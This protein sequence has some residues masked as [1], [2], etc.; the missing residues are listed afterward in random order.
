MKVCVL[1]LGIIGSAWAG[2]LIEDGH[3]VRVWNRTP[4]D[5]PGFC[6]IEEAVENAEAIF[7]V[8]ADPAAVESVLDSITPRLKAGQTVIQAST[9]S[10]DWS[11]KFASQVE[12][13]G[14]KF[15]EAPFT[16]S[17]PAAQARKTVFYLGGEEEVINLARPVL[18][19]LSQAI[20]HIGPVGAAS[21]LKLAMNINIAGV[22]QALCESLALARSQGIS[23]EKFFDAL[24]LN[25][26]RSGVSDLKEPKLR[27]ED[28]APQFS[29]KHMAKDIRLALETA[30]D[31]ELPSTQRTAEIY[32]RAI[33][34]GRQDDDFISLMRFLKSK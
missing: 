14:A 19:P 16:G 11:K 12:A 7:I 26:S 18:E 28:Y 22:A 5:F 30:G 25:A 6:A 3:D 17:K 2:N 15:L 10:S 21:S 4:K 32:N 1:G 34:T 20:L 27:E 31:L 24:H 29:V 33:E 13:T 23:D 8:V 9:I